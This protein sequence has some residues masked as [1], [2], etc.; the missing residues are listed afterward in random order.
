MQMWFNILLKQA[1]K[2]WIHIKQNICKISEL[3]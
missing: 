2:I 1:Y 3:K